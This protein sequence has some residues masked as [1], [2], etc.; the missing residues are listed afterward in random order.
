M[1]K[2]VPLM[3]VVWLALGTGMA[4]AADA[5]TV[6]RVDR[7]TLSMTNNTAAVLDARVRVTFGDGTH[8]WW[9]VQLLAS[10]ASHSWS[11]R[12][13]G[14]GTPVSETPPPPP[15]V[16]ASYGWGGRCGNGAWLSWSPVAGATGYGVW[17]ST[18][19]VTYTKW[20]IEPDTATLVTVCAPGTAWWTVTT[21]IGWARSDHSSAY[22]TP[23][24]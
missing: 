18:D 24:P 23:S 16:T 12:V 22:Q 17:E 11:K 4:R 20:A 8:T 10:S 2:F 15:D 14:W 9:T 5:V 7:H 21:Y 13:Q 3:A 19:G 6:T 1:R